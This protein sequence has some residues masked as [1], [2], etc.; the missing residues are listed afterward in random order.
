MKQIKRKLLFVVMLVLGSIYLTSTMVYSMEEVLEQSLFLPIEHWLHGEVERII[1][2]KTYTF[3]TLASQSPKF[4]A[5]TKHIII[6]KQGGNKIYTNCNN[7][8][9]I[10][11]PLKP[12]DT[13]SYKNT[14]E[15]GGYVLVFARFRRP[16]EEELNS[17]DLIVISENIT[18]FGSDD[19]KKIDE[20]IDLALNNPE[21]REY[22][23]IK[24]GNRNTRELIIPTFNSRGY[25][26]LITSSDGEKQ[27]F[28]SLNYCTDLGISQYT[29]IPW[30]EVQK[31]I[32]C[33]QKQGQIF[34]TRTT[35][36]S[37]PFD[38]SKIKFG[39]KS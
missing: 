37:G 15:K 27:V 3:W 25:G 12:I 33:V 16:Q 24:D 35:V 5:D 23:W 13:E 34:R 26:Y 31:R 8:V 21:N 22:F 6:C 17:D 1:S 7:E 38:F 14:E 2:E 36:G 28:W 29:F 10:E 4:K 30:E 19:Q 9:R 39:T 20:Q 32:D 18:I 11:I